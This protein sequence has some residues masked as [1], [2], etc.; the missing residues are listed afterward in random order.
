ME[1]RKPGAM[2]HTPQGPSSQG[3]HTPLISV[4]ITAFNHQ[5]LLPRA[6]ESVLRQQ[7]DFPIEIIIGDDCSSDGTVAVA[8]GYEVK[9][10]DVVH[11]VQRERN[12]GIQR[13]YYDV[14]ERCRGKYIA[15]LDADDCWTDPRKLAIQADLLESDS[16]V[17][18]CGHFTRWVNLAGEVK[19]EKYPSWPAGRYGV[20]DV[21]AKNFLMSQSV[22]FRNGIHRKL[23][24]WYFDAAPL[25]DWPVWLVAALEGDIV[26]LDRVM[27]DYT[28]TPGSAM[29]SKGPLYWYETDIRFY[30]FVDSM[31]PSHLR[32]IARKE[33]GKRYETI[34]SHFTTHK[35]F[36]GASRA[37]LQAFRTPNIFD[38]FSS[39]TKGLAATCAYQLAERFRRR[40]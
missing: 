33:K 7:T 1:I 30:E 20:K 34:A 14:F 17:M 37:A 8:K 18:A 38:N 21:L 32:R 27:A 6:I 29:M 24:P 25:T 13:N 11:V 35:D 16:T 28:L 19:R 4:A 31:L 39:K 22:V 36:A 23:P 5:E 26:L 12:I 15:W 3:P 10:P 40:K 9:F 2:P